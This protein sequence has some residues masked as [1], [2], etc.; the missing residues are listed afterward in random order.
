MYGLPDG[1]ILGIP[2]KAVQTAAAPFATD[3]IVE[4]RQESSR[5][6]G[7]T[8][9]ANGA[10]SVDAISDDENGRKVSDIETGNCIAVKHDVV[11][12]RQEG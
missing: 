6:L 9:E 11:V 7:Y 8:A 3:K 5:G 1:D 12:T 4:E 2:L 10:S